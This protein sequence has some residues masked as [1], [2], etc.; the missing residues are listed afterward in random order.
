M[1]TF[2]VSAFHWYQLGLKLKAAGKG[3][4]LFGVVVRHQKV[5]SQRA[6]KFKQIFVAD[7]GMGV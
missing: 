6:D 3:A 5:T 4:D 7:Y 2:M 1:F